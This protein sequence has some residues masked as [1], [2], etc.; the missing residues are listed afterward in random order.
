MA[1]DDDFFAYDDADD[2][3]LLWWI[4]I[5][6]GCI[7]GA[8]E[9]TAT[10]PFEYI[11]TQLQL[12]QQ[13]DKVSLASCDGCAAAVVDPM[14]VAVPSLCNIP[15]GAAAAC[16]PDAEEPDTTIVQVESLGDG[17]ERIETLEE[18][19]FVDMVGGLV[20]TVRTYGFFAL[21]YGLTPTL[22]GSVPKAGIRFGMFAW[23]SALLRDGDGNLSVGRIL[24][25]GMLAG[26][27]EAVLVVAP[28][29]TIKTKCI[30]LKLPFCQG[31]Q[32]IV[33]MEGVRGLFGGVLATCL[34]QSSNHGLRF[35]CYAEYKRVVSHDGLY[36]LSPYQ[37]FIG[38]MLAGVFSAL[39][40]QPFDVLKTRMQG[41]RAK[42]MYANTWD[43]VRQ[44]YAN[45]GVAGF[46]LGIVPRLARV[47]PGQGIIFM[48]FETIVILLVKLSQL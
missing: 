40:N 12:Q 4:S 26:A 22:L 32:A 47:I 3:P 31:L 10:W 38:G 30:H 36:E 11:K 34:K 25:A 46:Y 37:S 18:P 1:Y 48:S 14:T 20:Y 8:I 35:V 42:E 9:T 6:A 21:Y 23:F 5:V 7:A 16:S 45:E 41:L 15:I 29:E 39:G 17:I 19:P 43:C 33:H 44:T 28:V 2:A 13:H 24:L 27:V